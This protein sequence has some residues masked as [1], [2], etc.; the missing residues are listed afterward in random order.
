MIVFLTVYL[1]LIAGRQPVELKVDPAVKSIQLLLDGTKVQTLTAAP[2]RTIVDL[3]AGLQPHELAAVGLNEKGEEIARASQV[4]NVPVP[5]A[6]VDIET[7]KA[8][9]KLVP[10][11]I[12]YEKVRHAA[13]TLD[14]KPLGLDRHHQASL[15]EV[16]RKRPHVLAA[17]V[18]FADGAVARREVVFGG[19]F[20]ETMPAPL[21][22]IAVT[23]KGKSDAVLPPECG[24][25]VTAV[26][27]PAPMVIVVRDPDATEVDAAL[28]HEAARG[29]S[30]DT[31]VTRRAGALEN[32]TTMRLLSSVATRVRAADRPTAVLFPPAPDVDASDGGLFWLLTSMRLG[33]VPPGPRQWS[34]AVAVAGVQAFASGRRRAVV[35][36]RGSALDESGQTPAA[37]RKYLDELGVPLFVWSVT[38][39]RPDLER[40][41]GPIE[42]VSN[43]EK[44][45]AAAAKIR[46]TLDAQRIA[47]V[48]A[49]PITALKCVASQPR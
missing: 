17:E 3:G 27:K 4:L 22:S 41:W 21:T 40:A 44:M 23:S 12:S 2:W 31:A 13:L 18:R 16:D 10:R 39:P 1:G 46:A 32:G 47:W 11:H 38:G 19:E 48:E 45:K 8:H 26:E 30:I 43:V 15:P 14:G 34:D 6:D 29:G 7:E 33:S 35:L 28:L 25:H 49:D 20:G 37:V 9:V 36:V 24:L 5:L 42:D